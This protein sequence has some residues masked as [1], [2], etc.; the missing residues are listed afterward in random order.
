MNE[1]DPYTPEDLRRIRRLIMAS[2]G[3]VP[4]WASK[5]RRTADFLQGL[6]PGQAQIV[7]QQAI[8]IGAAPDDYGAEDELEQTR[9]EMAAI[10]EEERLKYISRHVIEQRRR[11]FPGDPDP[12]D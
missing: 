12:V 7:A 4:D 8:A 3:A 2:G 11:Y 5:L 9:A 1:Y 10:A 6:S